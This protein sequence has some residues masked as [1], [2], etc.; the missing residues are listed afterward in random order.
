MM[1]RPLKDV[2]IITEG[3]R[4]VYDISQP[5]NSINNLRI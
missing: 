2:C 3:K 5:L 4:E 1:K